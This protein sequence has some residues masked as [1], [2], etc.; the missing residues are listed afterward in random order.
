MVKLPDE[1]LQKISKLGDKTDQIVDACLE[2]TGDVVLPI[3]RANLEAVIGRDTRFP[4]RSTGELVRSLGVSPPKL[5]RHGE[6]DIKIG[7]HEP[8]SDGNVNARIANILEYGRSGQAP[9]PFLKQSRSQAKRP[10]IEAIERT[11]DE[12]VAKL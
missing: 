5:N 10:A 8:R 7:F 12:E 9:R 1:F 2:A 11:F 6:R 3:V 4:S